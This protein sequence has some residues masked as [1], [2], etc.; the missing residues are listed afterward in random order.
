M[1]QPIARRRNVRALTTLVV[2]LSI[3][4]APRIAR[5]ADW[6]MFLGNPSH[7][8]ISTETLSVPMALE[9]KFNTV[10]YP[11]N[12]VSPVVVG[13]TVYLAAQSNVYALD[14]ETGEQKWVYPAEGPI[15]TPSAA[16]I[17]AT[18]AVD[19]GLLFVGASDGVMYALDVDTGSL[20]WQFHT[21]GHIRFSP[22]VVD[23]IVYF[24][25]DD[26]KVYGVDAK[27]GKEAMTPVV[28]GNNI[29]G[30]PT[31]A[32]GML[33]FT[34][35]DL[36][37][38]AVN[39]SSGKVKYSN[40]TTNTNVYATPVATDRYIY[41]VGGN[42]I[43]AM[44]RSGATRWFYEAHN[45][46]SDTPLVTADA[47]YFGDKAGRLYALDLKGREKWTITDNADRAMRFTDKPKKQS[48]SKD[49]FI[50]LAGA[51]YSSPTLSG[52]NILVGTNRGFLYAIDAETGHVKW[53]YGVFSNLPAGA[54][55]NIT[56]SPVVANGRLY[57]LSDDGALH[58]FTPESLDVEKP[59]IA[60]VTPVRATEMNGTPP[61]LF[62]A[63]VSDEGS[64]ID[65][66]SIKLSLDDKPVD[67]TYQPNSGWVYYKTVVTQPIEPM[68][69]GRHTIVLSV[70]DW[71]GNVATENW[72]FT[73]D[74][75][76]APS[77]VN[78]PAGT[79]TAPPAAPG[80]A[81]F[82]VPGMPGR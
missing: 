20:K 12:P 41:T 39:A 3:S 63:I 30:S 7:T 79:G 19:G 28:T 21:G 22:I 8:A 42:V 68:Q 27:T 80:N 81:G 5:A 6:P 74:N 25:S 59:E 67:F 46:I 62:G 36:N 47:V 56:S 52:G 64:G 72:S 1:P 77:V 71:K 73:V 65:A 13:K 49:P 66:H 75:T 76:L 55:T 61:I 24:G 17:K 33:Y 38:Y 57:V 16:T 69:D 26:Y 82:G 53:E 10:R 44:T 4:V 34:S 43:Y 11:N 31:Y 32:D 9:W 23:G 29:I 45:P 60:N 14:A 48:L 78:T 70:S 54:Y 37:F 40:R 15:G 51:L 35:A 58:C 50:Q 18:P 2:G